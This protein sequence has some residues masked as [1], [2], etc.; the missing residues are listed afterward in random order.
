MQDDPERLEAAAAYIREHAGRLLREIASIPGRKGRPRGSTAAPAD[1]A[2]DGAPAC[3]PP[4]TIGS[5]CGR[6]IREWGR[7]Q[8]YGVA[9]RGRIR[10]DIIEAYFAELANDEAA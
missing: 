5:E 2:V 4:V 7:A 6:K 9:D 8:G 10:A 1:A 3:H